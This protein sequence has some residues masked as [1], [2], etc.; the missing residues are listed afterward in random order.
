MA[1]TR[2]VNSTKYPIKLAL[3]ASASREGW[4][5][6]VGKHQEGG[7]IVDW[8]AQIKS[9]RDV[10]CGYVLDRC[11]LTTEQ[12]RQWTGVDLNKPAP[13]QRARRQRRTTKTQ[14]S[15]CLG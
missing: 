15:F 6:I 3:L 1:Y 7:W 14:L 13:H 12:V 10:E 4:I 2:C 11:V 5:N 9:M 8:D